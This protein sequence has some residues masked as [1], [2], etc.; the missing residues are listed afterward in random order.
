MGGEISNFQALVRNAQHNARFAWVRLPVIVI[1]AGFIWRLCGAEIALLWLATMLSAERVAVHLRNRIISGDPSAAY[2]HLISLG[3]MSALWVCF[4]VLVWNSNTELGRIAACIGLL[5]TALYGALGGQKDLRPA[6]ILA[7]PPLIALF[8]LVSLHAWANWAPVEAFISTL[9]TFGAGVSVFT[10]ARALYLS[11]ASHTNAAAQ[12]QRSTALLEETSSVA[13]VGGWRYDLKAGTLDWTEQALRMLG[14]DRA[15]GVCANDAFALLAPDSQQIVLAAIAENRTSTEAWDFE[16]EMTTPAGERKW[17]RATAK[18]IGRNG[19]P[20]A[21]IGSVADITCRKQLE[22][23]LHHAQKLESIGRLTGGLAHDFNNILTA[24]VNATDSLEHSKEPRVVQAASVINKA[25]ERASEL[26]GKLLAF[27]RQ[28]VLHP[29]TLDINAAL[30]DMRSLIT[31]ALKGGVVLEFELAPEPL[32]TTLDD[33]QLT[34]AVLNLALNA[35]DAM[36]EGGRIRLTTR[37]E[38][39]WVVLEV[40]DTGIGMSAAQIERIFEPFFTNKP[41]GVGTGLGL[42]MVHGFITQSGGAISVTS[43][44]NAGS[45]FSLRFPR[46]P[47]DAALAP[48]QTRPTA[49]DQSGAGARVLLVDDDDLVREALCVALRARGF[50]VVGAASSAASMS[51]FKPGAFDFA[52][53]DVVLGQGLSGGDLVKH[54]RARDGALRALLVSGYTFN[55]DLPPEVEFLAKPFS[56]DRLAARLQALGANQSDARYAAS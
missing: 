28:Q 15:Q 26:T 1:V 7:A 46:A 35:S 31:S 17:L 48:V 37:G 13:E 42:A 3:I 29:V 47:A 24:I 52:V 11:D 9:A 4:G 33:G 19:I 14:L 51:L 43:A 10:C 54:L 44:P 8:V 23:E 30:T 16:L 45:V 21:L 2:P 34:N 53:V 27:S 36:P 39:D 50:H 49:I 20:E 6:T 55:C 5:T 18:T 56:V 40:A 32:L 41:A 22:T 25:S 12:L 38:A